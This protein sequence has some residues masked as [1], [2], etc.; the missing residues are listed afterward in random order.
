MIFFQL[1]CLAGLALSHPTVIEKTFIVPYGSSGGFVRP[2]AASPSPSATPTPAPTNA[3][4][5]SAVIINHCASPVYIWSVGTATRSPAT[6]LPGNRYGET[7]RHDH[8]SGGIALKISTEQNGLYNSAP[9]T[10]FAYNINGQNVW[11]D[12]SD[13]FGDPF[14]GHPVALSPAEPAIQ[15]PNGIQPSGSQVRVRELSEDLVL[16]LC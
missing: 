8:K 5:G 9:L 14:K 1:L 11:Y 12:L 2:A 15:W 4:I 3:R 7:F 13:V 16:T 10:V 6:V